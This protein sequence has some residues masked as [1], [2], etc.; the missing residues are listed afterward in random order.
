MDKGIFSDREKAMEATYFRR[1]DARL[2]EKL[3]KN[4]GWTI[5]PLALARSCRSIIRNCWRASGRLA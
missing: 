4:A 1:E 2:L 5:S 3:R